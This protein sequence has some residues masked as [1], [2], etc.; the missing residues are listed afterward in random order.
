MVKPYIS[1]KVIN[2]A[3]RMVKHLGSSKSKRIFNF[4]QREK[5]KECVFK[6]C[7]NYGA[8]FKNEGEYNSKTDLVFA[9]KAFLQNN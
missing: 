8:G 4:I 7:V 2:K 6:V 1:L 3:G 9:L 5:F